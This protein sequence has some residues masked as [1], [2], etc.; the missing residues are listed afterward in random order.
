M[1]V[2][3][4]NNVPFVVH[5]IPKDQLLRAF[6]AQRAGKLRAE[7]AVQRGAPYGMSRT[8]LG[9]PLGSPTALCEPPPWGMLVG[10]NLATGKIEWSKPLGTTE[11]IEPKIPPQNVG[12]YGF[13]GPIITAGGLVFVSGTAGDDYLRAFD[14]KTGELLWKGQLPAGGQAAPMTYSVG[15]KQYVVIAAG[16]HG[17]LGTKLGDSLVAF[18]LP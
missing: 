12:V 1:F 17:K 10:V 15:G 3:F 8:P 9:T 7:I 4:V 13:G 5:L 18:S 11:E 16:G 14:V 6:F 2:T